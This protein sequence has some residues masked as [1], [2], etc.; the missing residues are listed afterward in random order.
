MRYL[1]AH[2]LPS[3][4]MLARRGY[5]HGADRISPD[6]S[7][8]AVG[9]RPVGPTRAVRGRCGCSPER[10][11]L[12]EYLFKPA[13]VASVPSLPHLGDAVGLDVPGVDRHL[14]IVF[15]DVGQV[16]EEIGTLTEQLR[17]NPGVKP[18][19]DALADVQAFLQCPGPAVIVPG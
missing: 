2:G 14:L 12:H 10:R 9:T 17:V 15:A 1:R 7:G 3:V 18:S 16:G 8:C 11:G 19:E 13:S 5:P 4:T 6:E